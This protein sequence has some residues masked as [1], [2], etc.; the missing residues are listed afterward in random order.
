M[1]FF[2]S[3][4]K[5]L[6]SIAVQHWTADMFYSEVAMFQWQVKRF[7]WWY[8]RASVS[9][10]RWGHEPGVGPYKDPTRNS[11]E[12]Y[13]R[14]WTN[15]DLGSKREEELLLLTLQQLIYCNSYM[16]SSFYG[17]EYCRGTP[18][19]TLLSWGLKLGQFRYHYRMMWSLKRNSC[20]V[21]L[22]LRCCFPFEITLSKCLYMPSSV[23][24]P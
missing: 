1:L 6:F 5:L 16:C 13:F 11:L 8:V 23:T 2:I 4:P 3:C 18:T 7:L 12:G 22:S 15:V 21:F 14:A 10:E 17:Y 9:Q 24:A 20:H 19:L